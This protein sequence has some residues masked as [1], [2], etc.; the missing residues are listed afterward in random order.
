MFVGKTWMSRI[1]RMYRR[2]DLDVSEITDVRGAQ[3]D[4]S[5]NTNTRG[6]RPGCLRQ[7]GGQ[8]HLCKPLNS[9]SVNGGCYG[10]HDSITT[11]MKLADGAQLELEFIKQYLD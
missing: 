6:E 11:Q 1:V 7:C 8:L 9:G 10:V 2:K 4:V 5:E 3:P